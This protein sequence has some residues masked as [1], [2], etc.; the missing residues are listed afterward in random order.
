L[1]ILEGWTTHQDYLWF[2]ALLAW[3]GVLFGEWRR[4]GGAKDEPPRYWLMMLAIS[5]MT[6]ALLEL[7]LL[8]KDILTPYTKS[9]LAMGF[10]QAI[11]SSAL[12]WGGAIGMRE[13]AGNRA[14]VQGVLLIVLLASAAT[15]R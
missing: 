15:V 11:G 12:V 7:V 4:N 13:S 5:G 10:V 2:L 9:D 6:A 14:R 8:A 3:G 1:R